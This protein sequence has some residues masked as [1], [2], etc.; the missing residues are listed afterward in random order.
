MS[1]VMKPIKTLGPREAWE[2]IQGNPRT[3][4][5]DV[6]S[7]MEHLMIGHPSGAV[8]ISWIDE[9]DWQVN[10]QQF[11]TAVRKLMLGG[12]TCHD[13]CAPIVLICRSGNR[14]LDAAAALIE[15]GFREVYNVAGGFEGPLDAEHHRSTVAGWR[16]EGLPWQQG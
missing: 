14:S 13:D 6:R 8:H 5:I 4:L 3:V 2:L 7:A 16:F 12:I 1:P 10:P 15:A 11:V 9:P